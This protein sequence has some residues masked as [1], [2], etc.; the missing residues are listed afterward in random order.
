MLLKKVTV[1]LFIVVL[2]FNTSTIL[3]VSADSNQYNHSELLE[4]EGY[5]DALYEGVVKET[6]YFTGKY[7]E[8]KQYVSDTIDEFVD[9]A[10]FWKNESSHF[11]N[12][13]GSYIDAMR[14]MLEM[15]GGYAITVGDWFK[16]LF[17]DY[18]NHVQESAP[19]GNDNIDFS[20][21]LG[22]FELYGAKSVRVK[23]GYTVSITYPNGNVYSMKALDSFAAN[24]SG[25]YNDSEQYKNNPDVNNYS[26]TLSGPATYASETYRGT[27]AEVKP[28]MDKFDANS[29]TLSGRLQNLYT[30][31][32]SLQVSK[33]GIEIPIIKPSGGNDENVR[34]INNYIQEG[35]ID[36]KQMPIPEPI[37]YLACPDET[38]LNLKING[39]EFITVSGT[40]QKVN[41]D[42]SAPVGSQT[43]VL[44]WNVPNVSYFNDNAVIEDSEGNLKDVESGETVQE[45]LAC[46]GVIDGAL[47]FLGKIFDF[48]DNLLE[49]ITEIFIPKDS[50]FID[51]GFNEIQT[52]FN[53]KFEPIDMITNV[54]I[55]PFEEGQ[56]LSNV[57]KDYTISLPILGDK[58]IKIINFEYVDFAVPYLKKIVGASMII[59][60]LWYVYR[61]IT[62]NGGVMEK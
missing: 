55:S 52:L 46:S 12:Y 18:E 50:A 17:N 25:S 31:G 32:G 35:G 41:K 40:V 13:N 20:G 7:T 59:Y 6:T 22:A 9:Y 61:K 28:V 47:C 39:S 33:N 4:Y 49:F 58:P 10:N 38:I 60:T 15:G 53:E 21:V 36:N 11:E 26:F 14:D 2:L 45:S 30:I 54:F 51:E 57:L 34:T 42:G 19:G 24:Y 44:D 3:P 62:G 37:P 48:L 56:G 8:N 27:Y 1:I 5:G 43:C 29:L 16:N 23:S